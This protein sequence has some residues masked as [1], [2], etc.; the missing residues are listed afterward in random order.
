M[1]PEELVQRGI[2]VDPDDLINRYD[3]VAV[4]GSFN[5]NNVF[6][7]ISSLCVSTNL[8]CEKSYFSHYNPAFLLADMLICITAYLHNYRQDVLIDSIATAPPR[9]TSILRNLDFNRAISSL[10]LRSVSLHSKSTLSLPI[11][12]TC[13]LNTCAI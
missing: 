5:E 11:S 10:F 13:T 3:R 1:I 12:A 2:F 4:D 6:I 9:T 7:C 8:A